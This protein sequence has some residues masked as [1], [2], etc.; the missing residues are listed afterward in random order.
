MSQS[1]KEHSEIRDAK[2][3]QDQSAEMSGQESGSAESDGTAQEDADAAQAR[4]EAASG[5]SKGGQDENTDRI[6]E[7]EAR[8]SALEAENSELK[9]Q[10]LRKQADF[11]NF[12]KRMQREKEEAAKVANKDLMLDILP[13]IDDFERAIKS[14][15][16]SRDFD[17]FHDGIKMIE[18]QFTGMLERKWGLQRFDSEGEEFDPQKHEAVAAIED[19]SAE[20]AVVLQDFQ[21]GY[22][23]HD[24]VLRSAMVRVSMPADNEQ[25]RDETSDEESSDESHGEN[26]QQNNG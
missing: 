3:K 5:G 12:R 23:L 22:F 21:K 1:K 8:I 25:G 17:A 2:D 13:V 26:D 7:L 9:E 24:K 6:A 16:E 18:K 14:A 20:K 15:E 10:Y 19:P 11:D 4:P